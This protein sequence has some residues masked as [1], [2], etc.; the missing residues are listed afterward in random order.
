MS[1]GIKDLKTLLDGKGVDHNL[2][3]FDIIT[4]P[5]KGQFI[6]VKGKQFLP[7][8]VFAKV[9]TVVKELN[10]EYISAGKESHFR[11]PIKTETPPFPQHLEPPLVEPLPE[12]PATSQIESGEDSRIPSKCTYY[13]SCTILVFVEHVEHLCLTSNWIHCDMIRAE[14][15]LKYKRTPSEWGKELLV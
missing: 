5:E 4:V 12:L 7:R 1:V 13:D 10:G 2:L 15:L 9:A 3:D 6:R 8:D 14:D 11:V